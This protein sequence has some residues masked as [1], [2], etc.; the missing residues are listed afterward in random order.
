MLACKN[1]AVKTVQVFLENGANV[2]AV[3]ESGWTALHHASQ[4][5][6][7][8][9]LKYLTGKGVD[10]EAK[11]NSKQTPLHLASAEGHLDCLKYLV[12]ER[13]VDVYDRDE[14][15]W[16]SLHYAAAN[17]HFACVNHLLKKIGDGNE[18]EER[19]LLEKEGW[20]VLQ[21]LLNSKQELIDKKMASF[22]F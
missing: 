21:L 5:G 12:D 1:K 8:D 9:S 22:D 3:D 17:K 18:N 11:A 10:P 6:C 14:N 13:H 15:G 16:T 20:K 2:N 4:S 19:N 7:I